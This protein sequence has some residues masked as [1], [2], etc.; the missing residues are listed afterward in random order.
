MAFEHGTER[1]TCK[2]CGATHE[3]K[4]SRMP[5]RE[6]STIACLACDGV[7]FSGKGLRD[8]YQVR[9]AEGS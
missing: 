8:Y 6:S 7:L 9:L 3:A 2:G 1:L 5:V 4:W